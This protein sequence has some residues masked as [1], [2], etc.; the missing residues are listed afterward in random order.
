MLQKQGEM[1][2]DVV[3]VGGGL[4]GLTAAMIMLAA[5]YQVVI[6]EKSGLDK[7]NRQVLSLSA[8]TIKILQHLGLWEY[9]H[10]KALAI[11]ALHLSTQG[12]WP[13]LFLSSKEAGS[14]A[15]GYRLLAQDLSDVLL[16]QLRKSAS[17]MFV[18]AADIRSV[19]TSEQAVT[20]FYEQ[21]GRGHRLEASLL[22][23]ADGSHSAMRSLANFDYSQSSLA[24]K[25][26]SCKLKTVDL[27]YTQVWQRFIKSGV[28]AAVPIN[29]ESSQIFMTLTMDAAHEQI[30]LNQAQRLAWMQSVWGKRLGEILEVGPIV[31]NF[32][33]HMGRALQ[34]VQPRIVLLGQAAMSLPP[35]AAQ[36]YNLAVRQAAALVDYCIDAAYEGGSIG[37]LEGLR[38]YEK[39]SQEDYDQVWQ[40][41]MATLEMEHLLPKLRAP[42]LALAWLG[43]SLP[44]ASRR[45]LRWGEGY[46]GTPSRLLAGVPLQR[47]EIKS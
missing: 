44:I 25:V 18:R 40:T 7:V 13:R 39:A 4:V 37:D 38:R 15:F 12:Q 46:L 9:L 5:G 32:P 33:L 21:L 36:G 27:C 16:K 34:R 20:V 24:Y 1:Q 29:K 30:M 2:T 6:L 47:W 45:L 35:I 11:E 42:L 19:T 22:L 43:L 17:C 28:L 23:A 14:D 3:I 10:A 31:F 26:L 8:A 41:V